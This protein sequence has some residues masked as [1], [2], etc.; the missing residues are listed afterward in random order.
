MLQYLSVIAE[1]QRGDSAS[2]D[3]AAISVVGHVLQ[4]NPLDVTTHRLTFKT[5]IGSWGT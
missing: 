1:S 2:N 3:R 4:S 5:N